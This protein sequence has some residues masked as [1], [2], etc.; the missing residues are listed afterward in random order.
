MNNQSAASLLELY[1]SKKLSPAEVIE[2]MRIDLASIN[3]QLNVFSHVDEDLARAEAKASEDRWLRGQPNGRLDGVPIPIKDLVDVSGMPTR[4]G[5]LTSDKNP[6]STDAPCVARLRQAGAIL[7]GKTTTPEFGWK[8]IT[9]GPLSGATRNPHDITR[10]SGGSSGGAAACVASGIT[11]LAHGN[12]GGGSIRIPASYCGIYGIKPT[13]GRVP[14]HPRGGAYDCLSSEGPLCRTVYDAALFLNE[15]CAPDS[16]DWLSLP[17]DNVDYTANLSLGVKGLRI[18]LCV[19]PGG[20]KAIDEIANA[21][22]AAA[23]EFELLGAHVEQ[24]DKIFDPLQP[25][26]ERYWLGGLYARLAMVPIEQRALIDADL[27]RV[28]SLGEDVSL[29]E[30]S[31]GVTARAVLSAK[32][33]MFHDQYDLLLC[34]TMPTDP[35]PVETLYHTAGFDRWQHATP[36]TV[37][38]NLTG[39]PAASI[40]C[41]VSSK[42]LPIGLQIVGPRFSDALVLQASAAYES[43][44]PIRSVE[45]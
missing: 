1:R 6:V 42:G 7:F 35:P 12:D 17:A 34:P 29:A 24:V 38:F 41:G 44:K 19:S 45:N 27:I 4:H 16:R 36:Y 18:G 30:F 31:D 5:S 23:A 21:V 28:A 22:T 37:P 33:A 26:F 8:G 32:L 14:N 20:V 9:D 13:F 40:P 39:Q 2:Q 43:V 11:A 3:P 10:T 15:V 25:I